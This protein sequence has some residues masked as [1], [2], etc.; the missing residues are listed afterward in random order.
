[1]RSVS[2]SRH[3]KIPRRWD[4]AIEA[5]ARKQVQRRSGTV[6]D[7][8]ADCTT[9]CGLIAMVSREDFR[10]WRSRPQGC[11]SRMALLDFR[12][13]ARRS[14]NKCSTASDLVTPKNAVRGRAVCD[15]V[16]HREKRHSWTVQQAG[17]RPDRSERRRY[18]QRWSICSAAIGGQCISIRTR[19][20]IGDSISAANVPNSTRGSGRD[21]E[22]GAELL[23]AAEL[24]GVQFWTCGEQPSGMRRHGA[25]LVREL[26][27][28][29]AK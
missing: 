28:H 23:L 22:R 13:R 27:R 29:G 24:C 21:R 6:L 12:V 1:V 9:G 17:C 11:R 20:T 18:F 10:R 7:G 26:I 3:L 8:V 2:E 19:R 16:G 25:W 4:G 15:R 5:I 14:W